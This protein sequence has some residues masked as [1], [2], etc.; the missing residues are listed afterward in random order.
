MI[1]FTMLNTAQLGD[2]LRLAAEK[3]G[4]R[5][6]PDMHGRFDSMLR[7]RAIRLGYASAEAYRAF[8]RSEESGSEWEEIVRHFTSFETF[9]FRDH[10]QFDLLRLHLLPELIKRHSHDRTLRLWSAGCASGE[11]AY[12]M[13]MLVDMMLPQREDWNIFILGT[14]INSHA[15]ARARQGRYGK[16]SFRMVPDGLQQRYFHSAGDEW[17]LDDRIRSMVTFRVSNLVSERFPDADAELHDMDLILCRNLFIYFAPA[18]VSAVAEKFTATLAEDG[19]LMTAHTELIGYEAQGLESRLFAEGV[20]YQKRAVQ[21]AAP[22][23]APAMHLPS[24]PPLP[25]RALPQSRPVPHAA[26][27]P[28]PGKPQLHH[29]AELAAEARKLA[30]RGE[31]ELAEQKCRESLALDPLAAAPYYLLAQLAQFRN[32]FEQAKA[33]LDKAIYLEPRCVYAHLELAALHERAGNIPQAHALRQAALGIARSM[34]AT[35]QIEQ[36]ER[37]AGEIVQWLA[38]WEPEATGG[39][40]GG[41]SLLGKEPHGN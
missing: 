25:S 11:E 23:A 29:A 14:D 18:A 5:I 17:A 41:N 35:A 2:T 4:L 38:Q 19:Y 6:P 16:W 1:S 3:T 15:I 40:G 33:C 12:S 26:A 10:G 21:A 37:T 30:D 28:A 22:V 39:E 32:D 20:V 36:Y 13:A 9:F 8:L 27:A 34:P 31:Y 24:H 7:E